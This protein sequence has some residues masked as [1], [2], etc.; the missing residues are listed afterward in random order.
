[1]AKFR[2]KPVVIDAY[3]WDEL[4]DMYL[5]THS[6]REFKIGSRSVKFYLAGVNPDGTHH[7]EYF[8]IETLEGFMIMSKS[9]MLIQGI[10]G[11]PYP[12]KI[13]IFEQTYEPVLE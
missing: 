13:D 3:T 1:M 9:D 12:C 5:S 7:D 4:M 10:V 11:E 2:K 8:E 6:E